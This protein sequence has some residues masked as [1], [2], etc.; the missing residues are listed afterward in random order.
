MDSSDAFVLNLQ[1]EKI[2]NWC[3]LREDINKP[4]PLCK[5]WTDNGYVKFL[6]NIDASKRTS[7]VFRR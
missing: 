4:V 2:I 7:F 1:F 5:D 6:C 3:C